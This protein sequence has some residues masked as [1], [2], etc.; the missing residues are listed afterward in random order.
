MQVGFLAFFEK[1]K[2]K[3]KKNKQHSEVVRFPH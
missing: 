3:N 1:I 2:Y